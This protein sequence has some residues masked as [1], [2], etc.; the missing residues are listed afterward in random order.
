MD[1]IMEWSH[2]IFQSLQR[3]FD[4]TKLGPLENCRFLYAKRAPLHQLLTTV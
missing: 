2:A 1:K 3:A 4:L